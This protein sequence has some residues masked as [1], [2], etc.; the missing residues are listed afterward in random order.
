M[1]RRTRT[2]IQK[3]YADDLK[4]QGL[5]F[6]KVS[7]PIKLIYEFSENT[8]EV[9]EKTIQKITELNYSRYK[10]LTY[11]KENK[12]Q[13][14]QKSLLVGQ[15]NMGGFMKGILVK[16]L[17]SS[18]YAF[19]MTLKRFID[20]YKEF[21]KMYKDN[22]IVWISK[23]LNIIEL[24]DN[25]DFEK[26][27]QAVKN[28]DAFKFKAEDFDKNFIID[29]EKDL[30]ILQNL[31]DIWDTVRVDDKLEYFINELKNNKNLKSN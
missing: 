26:I 3:T 13:S 20:S 11:V 10:P 21:I 30:K 12:L 4:K 6:P 27:E 5:K 29:L 9:F 19:E 15:T 23:K 14:S 24:L 31:K 8:E 17:E 22:G 1:I 16:R 18:K 25:E 28:E 7:D 2:E